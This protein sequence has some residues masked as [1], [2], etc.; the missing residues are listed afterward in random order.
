MGLSVVDF[1]LIRLGEV[2][3]RIVRLVKENL[4]VVANTASQSITM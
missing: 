3:V 1:R 4:C 2:A